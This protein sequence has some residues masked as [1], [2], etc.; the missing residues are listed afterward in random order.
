MWLMEKKRLINLVFSNGIRPDPCR[1]RKKLWQVE[2]NILS[3]ETFIGL[4]DRWEN[5]HII[6][7]ELERREQQSWL[8]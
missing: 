8:I 2:I 3:Q 4:K 1:G 5:L 6:C 7:R